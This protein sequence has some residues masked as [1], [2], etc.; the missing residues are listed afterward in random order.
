MKN[1]FSKI[2]SAL[3]CF[4]LVW[5]IYSCNKE[6]ND[7]P[8]LA[9]NTN[10][11]L[12]A[13]S[14]TIDPND[15][16]IDNSVTIDN[17]SNSRMPLDINTPLNGQIT[18]N[19]PNGNVVAAGM[20]FGNSGPI[21]VIPVNGSQGQTG[22][23]ISFPF[24]VGPNTCD[25]LSKVCHDIK[26][27]EFAVTSD[28]KISRSNIRDVAI[29]CGKCEEPSCRDLIYPPCPP[30]GGGGS[31]GAGNGS[32]TF[33][34]TGSLSGTSFC[35]AGIVSLTSTSGVSLIFSNAPSSGS[36]TLT[37]DYYTDACSTCPALQV[38]DDNGN[39]WI[40]VSGSG[41]WS[42]TTFKINAT[43]KTIPDVVNGGGSSFSLTA[44]INCN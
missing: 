12:P 13:G 29:M 19:A 38:T 30:T 26:C 36:S 44:S 42:G 4:T 6:K 39:T 10:L 24:Q 22:G 11:Q 31:G 23:T 32:M 33:S 35:D 21:N 16:E 1:K 18:F 7:D 20:R 5:V 34:P 25:N 15:V 3:L 37:S 8:V 9:L 40:A 14:Y 17:T 28:G 43:M 41:S 27:Y 2:V